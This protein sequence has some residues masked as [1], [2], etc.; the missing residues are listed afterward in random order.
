MQFTIRYIYNSNAST[1][2]GEV[3]A[4]RLNHLKKSTIRLPTHKVSNDFKGSS[5]QLPILWLNYDKQDVS[6]SSY[7]HWWTKR[8]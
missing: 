3:G 7:D 2:L 8:K 4:I 5:S 1:S 6:P